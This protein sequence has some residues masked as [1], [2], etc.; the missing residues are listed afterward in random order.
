ME[1]LAPTALMDAAPPR[2][3]RVL[4]QSAEVPESDSPVCALC[5]S[6]AALRLSY[7]RALALT[8]T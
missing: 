1:T 5:A 4:W 8:R 6:S 3:A 2:A 7:R